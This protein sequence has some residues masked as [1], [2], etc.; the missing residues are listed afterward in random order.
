MAYR[1]DNDTQVIQFPAHISF[2]FI[3]VFFQ[4]HLFSF[5]FLRYS[6]L[7]NF[8]RALCRETRL[9]QIVRVHTTDTCEELCMWIHVLFSFFFLF[10]FTILH[11]YVPVWIRSSPLSKGEKN[12]FDSS[13]YIDRK[14]SAARLF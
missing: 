2:C 1:S 8:M 11:I 13:R 4:G 14:K 7:H 5:S 12:H 3:V 9:K 10:S 6:I